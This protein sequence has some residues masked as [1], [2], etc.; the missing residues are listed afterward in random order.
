ME[1]LKIESLEFINDHLE[2]L[3]EVCL[4]ARISKNTKFNDSESGKKLLEIST[5]LLQQ[6]ENR[7]GSSIFIGTY[8]KIQRK[9][10]YKKIDKKRKLNAEA[11]SNPKRF[12]LRKVIYYYYFFISL[13]IYL[14]TY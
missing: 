10:E 1:L 4:R 7:V 2:P 8:G 14:Y 11:V 3:I 12:A 9:I 13:L 5:E 6:I